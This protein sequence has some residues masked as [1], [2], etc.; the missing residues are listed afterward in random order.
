VTLYGIDT[1]LETIPVL[2]FDEIDSTNT[3][4]RRRAEA[5]ETGPL[6]ITAGVQTAGRGRRGRNWDTSRGN[7]AATLL[8][9]TDAN[10]AEAAQL[11]FVAAFAIR[12]LAERFVPPSLVRFKWPNDVMVDGRKL[13]GILIESG[14][15]AAGL[16]W[17]AIGM[18]VNLAHAPEN[19]DRPA[20]SI[21]AHLKAGEAAPPSPTEALTV[22]SDA[23]VRHAAAWMRAGFAPLRDEW[24]K[25]A[26]GIG[27][28]CVARLDRETVEG[29][30][31]GLDG[32]GALLLRLPDRSL[33][34][35]SAG[36]VFFPAS[37]A[38][39]VA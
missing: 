2:A 27:Q 37:Q 20:T 8:I 21:A 19:V 39:G 24:L 14:R 13:S 28:A 29:V 38:F 18:G 33:R 22:L 1:G 23:F 26:A 7:L 9:V 5:G 17:L 3:E 30:A 36:D 16:L 10:P 32:D 15:N 25:G 12:A 4:A 35:I 31:E 11:S 34:R 6:W